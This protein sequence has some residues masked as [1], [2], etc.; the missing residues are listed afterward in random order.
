MSQFLE[1]QPYGLFES[2]CQSWTLSTSAA[3]QLLSQD[4]CGQCTNCSY[5]TKIL[6]GRPQL[7]WFS[8]TSICYKGYPYLI[9]CESL[10]SAL[11]S[12]IEAFHNFLIIFMCG[13]CR[14]YIDLKTS[15]LVGWMVQ[16]I[17]E[18]EGSWSF[19]VAWLR[20]LACYDKNFQ[21]R[22]VSGDSWKRLVAHCWPGKE[23]DAAGS[24]F[25]IGSYAM[26]W[27]M[28][29]FGNCKKG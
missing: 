8:K 24:I 3:V 15:A 9:F 20:T 17:R 16:T 29:W 10:V 25:L 21:V 12:S 11:R 13:K 27:L 23:G 28:L 1:W 14:K 5:G 4:D 2:I 26:C 22:D 18:V 7:D 6:D 19:L